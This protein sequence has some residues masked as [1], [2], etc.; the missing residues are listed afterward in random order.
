VPYRVYYPVTIY[1]YA[2]DYYVEHC[3]IH[4]GA[5]KNMQQFVPVGRIERVHNALQLTVI[6]CDLI[7]DL[8]VAAGDVHGLLNGREVDLNFVQ[9]RPGREPF[10]G[11]AGKARLSR[12]GRAVTFWFAEGMV[13]APL[14]QVRQLMT[15]GRKAAILSRPQAAPVID[16]DEEQRRPIDEGL[17]RSFT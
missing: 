10:V 16:A 14:V 6:G 11:Y 1:T 5:R 12:S 13:T 7:G 4:R 17:I 9:R 2:I 8:V 15:G 3:V